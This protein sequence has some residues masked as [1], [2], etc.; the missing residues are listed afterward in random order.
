MHT[1]LTSWHQKCRLAA[2]ANAVNGCRSRHSLEVVTTAQSLQAGVLINDRVMQLLAVGLQSFRQLTTL[3][4]ENLC[5]Q[6]T[7][8]QT[9]NRILLYT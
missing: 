6:Q 9:S 7:C 2:T 3:H 8:I 4:S 5:S 1:A